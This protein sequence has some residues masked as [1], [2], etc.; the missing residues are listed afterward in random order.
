MKTLKLGL[1]LFVV[2]LISSLTL[3]FF[4]SKTKPLIE[5]T[6]QEN[7][8]DIIKKISSKSENVLTYIGK[9][10]GYG[11]EL[12]L[13]YSVD[14]GTKKILGLKILSHKETPG[15]GAKVIEKK[16]TDQFIGKTTQQ[17]E[18]KK[19]FPDGTIDAITGATITSRAVIKAIKTAEVLK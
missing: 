14:A 19:D 13:I 6:K 7:K 9:T 17:L 18:L 16:F 1:I 10:K 15:L 2:C 4:Y 5:K 11:G 8:L 12:V 3:S